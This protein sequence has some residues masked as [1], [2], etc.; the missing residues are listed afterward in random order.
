MKKDFT[1]GEWKQS[2]RKIPNNKKGK[3]L[4]IL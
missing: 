4:L 2:H 3:G 1:P